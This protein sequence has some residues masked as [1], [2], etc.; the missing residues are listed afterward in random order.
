MYVC[1]C[2]SVCML[3]TGLNETNTSYSVTSQS[4]AA[5]YTLKLPGKRLN[6]SALLY[7]KKFRECDYKTGA[8]EAFKQ[9]ETT[10][11]GTLEET[12]TKTGT[13][14]KYM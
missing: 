7:A 9:L 10:G 12:K 11:L 8:I 4:S 3:M 6:L 5:G 2:V 13:K 14:V 1:T